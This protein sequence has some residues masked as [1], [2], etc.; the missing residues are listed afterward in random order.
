MTPT[1]R[2]GA[3]I[4]FIILVLTQAFQVKFGLRDEID[5]TFPKVTTTKEESLTHDWRF[6]V[7]PTRKT[8]TSAFDPEDPNSPEWGRS[9]GGSGADIITCCDSFADGTAVFAGHSTSR[10]DPLGV[11]GTEW[12]V[13]YSFIIKYN[14]FGGRVWSRGIGGNG[15]VS[16]NDCAVLTDGSVVA[17]GYTTATN[18]VSS[19]P[20]SSKVIDAF[21]CRYSAS[22][23]LLK[24]KVL[25]GGGYDYFYAVS[26]LPSGGF[27]AAGSSTSSDGDFSFRS[28]GSGAVI[29]AFDTYF[30]CLWSDSVDGATGGTFTGLDTDADGN[31]FAALVSN[32]SDGD[33]ASLPGFGAG[34][35][36]SAVFRYSPTGTVDWSVVIAGSGED[37]IESVAADGAGGCCA[38][39]YYRTYHDTGTVTGTY[40]DLGVLNFGGIDGYAFFIDDSGTVTSGR[41][42]A[43]MNEDRVTDVRRT[44]DGFVFCGYSY[45]WNRTFASYGNLGSADGFIAQ[46]DSTGKV[47]SLRSAAGSDI[48]RPNCVCAVGEGF[49]LAGSTSSRDEFFAKITPPVSA[50]DSAFVVKY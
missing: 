26:A 8:T 15:S 32:S 11:G 13:P 1:T 6:I 10:E 20:P 45:S 44:E 28:G 5:V 16:I 19:A 7:T 17:V 21:V 25:S 31:T 37:N 39:G 49:F 23:D 14:K 9:F 41:E 27:A 46:T 33:Y 38:A 50:D 42:F 35:S 4:L 47:L 22:G 48:D 30:N 29:M 2:L 3:L 18:L 40:A 24:L 34:Q 12:S 36:D 43:G